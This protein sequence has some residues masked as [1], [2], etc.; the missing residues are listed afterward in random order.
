MTSETIL[1]TTDT[2]QIIEEPSVVGGRA[3]RC[4]VCYIKSYNARDVKE[5]YCSSCRAS[6]VTLARRLQNAL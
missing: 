3:I 1:E 2:Y 4:Q 6:H 5:L